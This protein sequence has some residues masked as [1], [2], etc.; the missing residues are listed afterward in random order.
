MSAGGRSHPLGAAVWG[1]AGYGVPLWG[2]WRSDESFLYGFIRPVAGAAS[3]LT[4]NEA[5]YALELHP[6]SFV[7]IGVGRSFVARS[8]DRSRNVDCD[9]Y[10]CDGALRS[11]F[12]TLEILLAAGAWFL[13]SEMDSRDHLPS[14]DGEDFYEDGTALLGRRGGDRTFSKTLTVGREVDATFAKDFIVGL[15]LKR[16]EFHRSGQASERASLIAKHGIGEDLSLSYAA[17]VYRSDVSP[18]GLA[19][20]IS[21]NWSPAPGLTL[22]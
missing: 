9:R 7:G 3:A 4:I 14:G 12:V 10:M 19:V 16:V 20:G 1:E 15:T 8:Q 2:D 17:G 13:V 11:D 6:I 21:L 18:R 22:N 5:S